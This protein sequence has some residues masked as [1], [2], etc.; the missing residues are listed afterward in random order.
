MVGLSRVDP[1]RLRPMQHGAYRQIGIERQGGH[2][3]G[4]L[5]TGFERSW[6]APSSASAAR[7]ASSCAAIAG[8]AGVAVSMLC[9]WCLPAIIQGMAGYTAS[10]FEDMHS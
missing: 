1:A 7:A 4:G 2:G 5:D 10:A 6:S 3:L 8:D 9:G